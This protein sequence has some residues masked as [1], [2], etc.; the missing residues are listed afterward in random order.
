MILVT[1]LTAWLNNFYTKLFGFIGVS[2]VVVS[3]VA[4]LES[5]LDLILAHLIMGIVMAATIYVVL[6][7]KKL[8]VSFILEKQHMNV[9]ISQRKEA[10]EKLIVKKEQLER[11][12]TDIR[13]LNASLENKV[14]E[15]TLILKEALNELEKSQIEVK[16]ALSKEKE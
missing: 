1:L 4:S 14:E 6:Y 16:E 3:L 13:R 11:I 12:T 8:Y 15:R 10:E 9:L 7:V 5:S 2:M